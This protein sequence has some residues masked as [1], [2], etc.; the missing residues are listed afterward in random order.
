MMRCY[1]RKRCHEVRLFLKHIRARYPIK[2]RLYL[3]LD[4]FSPHKHREVRS[5]AAENNVKLV[6]TPTYASWR[7][8]TKGSR[9]WTHS[10]AFA[11]ATSPC[12][13]ASS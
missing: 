8:S 5:W 7:P 2:I 10:A 4:N 9:S 12:P 11:P 3:V 13:A 1:K 6:F